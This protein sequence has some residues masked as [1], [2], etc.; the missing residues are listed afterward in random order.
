MGN[1]LNVSFHTGYPGFP[2]PPS[3]CGE[4][5]TYGG[6]SLWAEKYNGEEP[7]DKVSKSDGLPV[8][9]FQRKNAKRMSAYYSPPPLYIFSRSIVRFTS[10]N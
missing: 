2:P 4:K 7:Q 6:N 10:G 9:L 8:I 5:G 1:R 3:K